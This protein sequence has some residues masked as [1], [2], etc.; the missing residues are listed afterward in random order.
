ME[1]AL[2][3]VGINA[4]VEEVFPFVNELKT[5]KKNQF[6]VETV[7]ESLLI[8]T[9]FPEVFF[10]LTSTVSSVNTTPNSF[11]TFI[12]QINIVIGAQ[13]SSEPQDPSQLSCSEQ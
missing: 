13:D 10:A 8:K 12:K 9:Y 3:L 4:Y 11:G 2:A 1:L 5:I 7:K 6:I